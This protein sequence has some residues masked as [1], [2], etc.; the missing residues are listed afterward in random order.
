MRE[1]GEDK[2]DRE[3]FRSEEF[4]TLLY[5]AFNQLNVTHDREKIEMLGV[6][7][8]NSGATRFKGRRTQRLFIHFVRELTRQHLKVLVE[9]AP[10]PLPST[11][12]NLCVTRQQGG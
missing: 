1:V 12:L 9:L 3:W 10:K 11:T 8:A 7:L 4:Q 6:A 2:V 5:E